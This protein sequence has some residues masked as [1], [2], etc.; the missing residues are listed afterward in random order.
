MKF[1]NL[2]VL[3]LLSNLAGCAPTTLKQDHIKQTPNIEEAVSLQ[4]SLGDK[5]TGWAALASGLLEGY[6]LGQIEE[7]VSLQKSLGDKPTGWAALASG[8]LEG[9]ALGQ[10]EQSILDDKE[11]LKK[12]NDILAKIENVVA[13]LDLI[14]EKAPQER[15]D[16]ASMDL[17]RGYNQSTGER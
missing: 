4:K 14:L 7:A 11:R 9:Y 15:I 3:L 5:P 1:K 2:I 8:L 13:Q 6:A 12:Y 17:T 16:L 10:K